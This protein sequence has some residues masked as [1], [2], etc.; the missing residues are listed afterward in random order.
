M[1]R[2]L[3]R[4]FPA[5]AAALLAT[6]VA[7]CAGLFPNIEKDPDFGQYFTMRASG[8]AE[9]AKLT[10]EG[11]S[12]SET[13]VAKKADG[14]RGRAPIGI[15]DLRI[16]DNHI[17]GSAGRGPTDLYVEEANNSLKIR[18]SYGGKLGE[19]ELT[20]EKL[21]GVVGTCQ[22]DL[23]RPKGAVWY[24]GRRSC[25][26]AMSGAELALPTAF[27]ARPVAERAL[28]LAVFLGR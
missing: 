5:A 24:T 23:A 8:T 20:P 19:I 2:T 11:L 12:G 14:Y 4:M 16:E 25:D 3:A 9:Q 28:L 10:A 7:G 6:L 1:T 15:V 18:G 26:V 27:E 22:Y 13:E 17:V 21:V